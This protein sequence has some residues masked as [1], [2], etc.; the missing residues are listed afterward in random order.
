[1]ADLAITDAQVLLVSGPVEDGIA[2]AAIPPGR[3]V[4]KK[5]TDSK[6]ALAQADG[7]AEEAGVGTTLGLSLN[8]A[9]ADGQPIRVALRGA[10]VT[11]GA[12]A[13]PVASQVYVVSTTAGAIALV[14]DVTTQNHRRSVIALGA[15]SNAVDVVAFA[16]G[17]D[18]P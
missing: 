7:T 11:L 10:R 8:E 6:W 1:M 15:G 16:P 13:A 14:S 9:N 17:D 4:Y 12:G 18:I 3:S 5:T 2:S